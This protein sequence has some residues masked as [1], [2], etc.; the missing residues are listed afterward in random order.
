MNLQSN[1]F[2][3][4][5][6]L[7]YTFW[8]RIIPTLLFIS[9]LSIWI[10]LREKSSI[11]AFM[12]ISVILPMFIFMVVVETWMDS[13][14][15]LTFNNVINYKIFGKNKFTIDFTNISV[16]ISDYD[17]SIVITPKPSMFGIN[18]ARFSFVPNNELIR[19]INFFEDKGV[20]IKKRTRIDRLA[21]SLVIIGS[22]LLLHLAALI[23]T[24]AANKDII[25]SFLMFFYPAL[26]IS[27]L[28]SL[29]CIYFVDIT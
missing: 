21:K 6:S 26:T 7:K 3:S 8:Y 15:E 20:I 4:L 11:Q 29:R 5:R 27:I 24:G 17:R 12:Y 10:N 18:S 2:I 16:S 23:L 28:S 14:R 1:A 22:I 9:I 25:Q 13:H 19:I